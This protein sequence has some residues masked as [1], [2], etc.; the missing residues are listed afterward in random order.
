MYAHTQLHT[1]VGML[2]LAMFTFALEEYI[3]VKEC[4]NSASKE[5]LTVVKN[6]AQPKDS[7]KAQRH[8][9]YIF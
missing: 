6:V 5:M 4:Y 2:V 8:I 7:N 3:A 9:F 1:G